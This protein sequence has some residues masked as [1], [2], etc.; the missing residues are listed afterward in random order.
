VCREHGLGYEA[1]G[2]L[3]GG[4]LAARYKRGQ[5]FPPGSRMTQRPEPYEAYLRD[6]VFDAVESFETEAG[7]RGVSAAALA[8]AWLLAQDEVTAV[9]AGPTRP[10]HL[11]PVEEALDV[12]LDRA[13]VIRI[14]EVF[15]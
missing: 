6:H 4:W 8:F 3:A 1:F 14:R 10:E 9:V 11:D 12:K 2:P 13:D 15:P 7:D 5:A